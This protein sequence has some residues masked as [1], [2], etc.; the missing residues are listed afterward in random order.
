MYSPDPAAGIRDDTPR[1]PLLRDRG[2]VRES[3]GASAMAHGI[4]DSWS[5][6]MVKRRRKPDFNID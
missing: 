1:S 3:T 2:A 5:E 6:L 4:C